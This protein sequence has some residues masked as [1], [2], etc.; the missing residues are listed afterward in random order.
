MV[1]SG[2]K[3]IRTFALLDT[4]AGV[5]IFGTQ[6]ADALGID[7]RECPEIDILGLGGECRGYAADVK[8][9][10]PAVAYAW[11]ARIV[12]SPGIDSGPYPILGHNG[13]FEYFEVRFNSAARQFRVHLK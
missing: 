10:I 4:G 3:R 12:F 11:P 7:W 8:L 1:V 9:V 5:T 6:H 2:S 13:F